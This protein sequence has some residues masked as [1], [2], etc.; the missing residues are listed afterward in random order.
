MLAKLMLAA[1]MGLSNVAASPVDAVMQ[2]PAGQ[3]EVLDGFQGVVVNQINKVFGTERLP[4]AAGFPVE[5]GVYVTI[6]ANQMTIFDSVAA[7]LAGGSPTDKTAAAECKSGC[8][9][10][11][12]DAFRR[13]WLSLEN[14]ALAVESEVPVRV[15][16]GADASIP[17]RSF[18]EAAYASAEARPGLPPNLYILLNGGPAGLRA[19]NFYLVPPEGLRVSP[20]RSPLGLTVDVMGGGRFEVRAADARKLSNTTANGADA[21]QKLFTQLD[22]RFPSKDVLIVRPGPNALVSDLVQVMAM[23]SDSF[24][25]VVFALDASVRVGG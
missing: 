1:L 16:F 20:S 21:L 6:G 10:V 5:P 24:P 8:S 11:F 13:A 18:I 17:A 4:A 7:T 2:S 14:E 22:R 12:Y 23:A 15:L 9:A 25:E 3:Y 19:R